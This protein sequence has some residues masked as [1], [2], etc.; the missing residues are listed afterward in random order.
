MTRRF[1]KWADAHPKFSI[2]AAILIA[3]M[4]LY[5]AKRIDQQNAASVYWSMAAHRSST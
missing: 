4:T 5:L 1:L 3:V 2:P